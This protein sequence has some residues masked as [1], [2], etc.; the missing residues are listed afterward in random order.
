MTAAAPA[1]VT[2]TD[3]GDDADVVFPLSFAPVIPVS[4]APD[5]TEM[6]TSSTRADPPTVMVT[7][8][9]DKP[10]EIGAVQI[11]VIVLT[12]DEPSDSCCFVQVLPP[13]SAIDVGR[14]AVLPDDTLMTATAIVPAAAVMPV[15]AALFVDEVKFWVK[16][17]ALAMLPPPPPL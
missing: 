4:V 2:V 6:L 5:H 15:T 3:G 7:V 17:A 14:L 13:A 8:P 11:C 10:D 16:S 9:D 12:P 1:V